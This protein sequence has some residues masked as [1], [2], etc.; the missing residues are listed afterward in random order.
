MK[1]VLGISI[2][3]CGMSSGSGIVSLEYFGTG[4]LKVAYTLICPWWND[5]ID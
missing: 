5:L 2:E 3:D 1:A 4:R